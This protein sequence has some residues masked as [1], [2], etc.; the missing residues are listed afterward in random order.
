MAEL[1]EPRRI[2]SFDI[3]A[4]IAGRAP[5][6]APA[7]RRSCKLPALLPAFCFRLPTHGACGLLMAR[8]ARRQ[9]RRC[10]LTPLLPTSTW[11][12]CAPVDALVT[13]HTP[14]APAP[15]AQRSIPSCLIALALSQVP[16]HCRADTCKVCH[17]QSRARA[18]GRALEAGAGRCCRTGCDSCGRHRRRQKPPG[19]VAGEPPHRKADPRFNLLR[20]HIATPRRPARNHPTRAPRSAPH[21]AFRTPGEPWRRPLRPRS[22]PFDPLRPPCAAQRVHPERAQRAQRA[23]RTARR[24][25]ALGRPAE[26]HV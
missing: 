21:G 3:N 17:Q 25:A 1:P 20:W 19:G 5:A 13:T 7:I 16:K 23:H 4:C 10:A 14:C 15:V 11:G 18:A 8:R 22:T 2:R 9:A 24:A 26:R 6:S 12:P